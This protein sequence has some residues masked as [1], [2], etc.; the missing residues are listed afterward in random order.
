MNEEFPKLVDLVHKHSGSRPLTPQAN[1][2]IVGQ[3]E[4][5]LRQIVLNMKKIQLL[6]RKKKVS[7]IDM[8]IIM[9][10]LN[11]SE[12]FKGGGDFNSGQFKIPP[13]M[14]LS[15][16]SSVDI[17]ERIKAIVMN[18]V[19]KEQMGLTFDWI[20]VKGELQSKFCVPKEQVMEKRVKRE[21]KS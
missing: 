16:D 20:L 2:H 11:L 3:I 1:S 17:P 9:K 14:V 19:K 6:M 13:N 12:L 10:D 21:D 7:S 8:D 5:L 4:L 15:E 18:Q